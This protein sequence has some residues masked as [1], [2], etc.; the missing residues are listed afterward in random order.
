[1]SKIKL[2]GKEV[3]KVGSTGF[4]GVVKDL[5]CGMNFPV[6]SLHRDSSLRSE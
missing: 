3:K 2:K 5:L 1:M 4:Q 6:I